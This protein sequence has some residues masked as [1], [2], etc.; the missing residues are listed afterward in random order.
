M[1][2][3]RMSH[4]FTLV[5]PPPFALVGGFLLVFVFV[6]F[7]FGCLCLFSW[8]CKCK[9]DSSSLFFASSR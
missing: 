2:V 3:L 5:S 4:G 7:V 8:F 9:G 1:R 6:G